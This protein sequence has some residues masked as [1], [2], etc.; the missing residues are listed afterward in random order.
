MD[1][2]TTNFGKRKVNK[3]D[4]TKLVQNIF[5]KVSKKYNLMND[6]MSFGAH[7]LWK[8]ELISMMQIQNNEIIIDVGSGTGD[9]AKYILKTNFKGK[10]HLLDLNKEMLDIGKS[11]IGENKKIFFT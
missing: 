11:L 5:S 6:I 8:K 7:R 4:K 10:L 9:I 1:N 3:T 2:L